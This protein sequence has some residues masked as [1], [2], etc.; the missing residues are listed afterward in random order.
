MKSQRLKGVVFTALCSA[1]VMAVTSWSAQA[2]PTTLL[3][4][5]FDGENG[6]VGQTNFNGLS[7]WDVTD[8]AVDLLG[9]GT[10]DFFP[11][12]G[13][14]LD[15]DGTSN[16]A[17]RL[18]SATTFSFAAGDTATLTFDLAGPCSTF[19]P[20]CSRFANIDNGD[21]EVAVSLGSLFQETFTFDFDEPSNTTGEVFETITR[22]IPIAAAANVNLV[23][24]HAGG[25]QI[26]LILD[27]VQL[28]VQSASIPEP[29]AAGLLLVG[30][31]GL[32]IS[33]RRRCGPV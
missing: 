12:N 10:I 28:T 2:M 4:D 20:I 29:A 30:L 6:G 14:Y 31:A 27:N 23:F 32:V 24:D 18:E 9:N 19:S 22:V 1:L 26:G 5:N 13:L 33:A 16:D 25:D 15:L 11:G 17:A 8:G 3:T 21:N 7:N